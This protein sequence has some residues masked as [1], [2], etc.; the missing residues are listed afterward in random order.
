[1]G[2]GGDDL[3]RAGALR[4][5][6]R[7]AGRGGRLGGGVAAAASARAGGGDRGAS[8]A[9]AAGQPG[10]GSK[11]R[12]P[13]QSRCPSCRRSAAAAQSGQA[14]EMEP[15]FRRLAAVADYLASAEVWANRAAFANGNAP[16]ALAWAGSMQKIRPDGALDDLRRGVVTLSAA[17]G[18]SVSAQ[19]VVVPLLEP[20]S[21]VNARAAPL[22]GTRGTVPIELRRVAY[23]EVKQSTGRSRW[24][25]GL[26]PDPLPPLVLFD[27]E[28]DKV[29]PAHLAD[30]QRPARRRGRRLP[31]RGQG[32]RQRSARR[33]H[34]RHAE[35]LRLR[36][37]GHRAAE[38]RL[39]AQ[40]RLHRARHHLA[41][42]PGIPAGWLLGKW[43]GADVSGV[44]DYF[45]TAD[46]TAE[47]AAADGGHALRMTCA[48]FHPGSCTSARGSA[49]TPSPSRSRPARSTS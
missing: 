9:T 17:R 8:E 21:G 44:A 24:P 1:M 32:D 36:A 30:A 2:A 4:P 38:E 43:V 27:V 49:S 35:G 46:F 42:L 20:L 5:A 13:P 45:G 16:F 48:N 10:D 6:D 19:V 12:H 28:P 41:L 39:R 31:R 47:R 26:W 23:V 15:G 3:P 22:A 40:R 14:A 34:S 7:A 33:Q 29:R 25:K 11:G 18:K 37:A